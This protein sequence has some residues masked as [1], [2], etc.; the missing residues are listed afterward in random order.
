M[1]QIFSYKT[2]FFY[3]VTTISSAFLP[4]MNESLCAVQ[5]I[6]YTSGDDPLSLSPLLKCTTHGLTALTF[7][8]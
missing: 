2:L 8:T 5:V 6:I 3:I 4:A 7:T 1:E